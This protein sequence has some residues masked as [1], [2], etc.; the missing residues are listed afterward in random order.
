[1]RERSENMI[2][3]ISKDYKS[4]WIKVLLFKFIKIYGNNSRTQ[5]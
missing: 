1:M 5:W 2:I 3:L 4:Y